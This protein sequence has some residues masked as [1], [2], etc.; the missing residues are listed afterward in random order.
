ME[1]WRWCLH[2]ERAFQSDSKNRCGYKGCDGHIGDI[3]DWD[4][5]RSENPSYPETPVVGVSYPMYG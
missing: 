4:D 3:W 5:I 1:K 2:C